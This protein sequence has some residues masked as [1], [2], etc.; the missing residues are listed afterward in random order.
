[1]S[2]KDFILNPG[3]KVA[4]RADHSPKGRTKYGDNFVGDF[5]GTDGFSG[6]VIASGGTVQT[7]T[8]SGT[9]YTSRKYTGSGTFNVIRGGDIGYLVVAG[10][11]WFGGGECGGGTPGAGGMLNSDNQNFGTYGKKI[12]KAPA[13]YPVT[14]GGGGSPSHLGASTQSLY[15]HTTAGGQGGGNGSGYPGGS[16]GGAGSAYGQPNGPCHAGGGGIGGQGHHG[17]GPGHC[18]NQCGYSPHGGG[19]GAGSHG[20]KGHC[21]GGRSSTIQ[22]GTSRNYAGG[23]GAAHNCPPCYPGFGSCGGEYGYGNGGPGV[24]IVAHRS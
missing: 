23:A 9:S 3:I 13:T 4:D 22:D 5:I 10:G 2:A 20:G 21:G 6:P 18:H 8:V 15:I 19:G 7:Y 11:G 1:M 16:G 24:V 14:V 17:G 12:P